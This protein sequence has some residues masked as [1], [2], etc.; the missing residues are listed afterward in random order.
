VDE[1]KGVYGWST[2]YR[3]CCQGHKECARLLIDHKANVNAEDEGGSSALY[4]A[5]R[6]QN[7]GCAK[8][9]VQNGADVNRQTKVG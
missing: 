3:V 9:L 5:V 7:M 2:L 6:M 1:H 4:R 8:L